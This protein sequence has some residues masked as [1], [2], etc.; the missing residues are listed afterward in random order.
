[1]GLFGRALHFVIGIDHLVFY[2]VGVIFGDTGGKSSKAK[3]GL[4]VFHTTDGHLR[5]FCHRATAKHTR[6]GVHAINDDIDFIDLVVNDVF[7]NHCH[8]VANP[9]KYIDSCSA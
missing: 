4:S 7:K 1:M 2:V 8:K 6:N 5:E 3:I 9:F